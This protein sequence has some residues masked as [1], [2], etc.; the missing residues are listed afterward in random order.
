MDAG[1]RAEALALLARERLTVLAL[2]EDVNATASAGGS[3]KIVS[4]DERVLILS[5]LS[6]M[7]G[8]G[9]DLLE[10][11]ETVSSALSGRPAETALK[12]AAT[13]LRSGSSLGNSLRAAVQLPYPDYVYALIDAGEASG[14][15]PL[16]LDIAA[17]RLTE[18]RTFDR[19]LANAL[20]YPA[21]L[22]VSGVL[23]VAFLLYAVVP[24]FATMLAGSPTPPKGLAAIVIN[25]GVWFHAHALPVLIIT[26]VLG[27]FGAL[28][29]QTQEGAR[30]IAALTEAIP[31]VKSF[32]T[33][34]Q[35]A[36]WSRIM[37]LGLA[38]G[39][40]V[41]LAAGI[42]ARSLPEG[43]MKVAAL[44]AIPALRNGVPVDQAYLQAGVATALDASL[45]RAGQRSGAFGQMFGAVADRNERDMKDALKRIIMLAEPLAIA[46]VA[47]LIGSI[48]IG[49]V[50]ALVSIYDSV[51]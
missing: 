3:G 22:V 46:T 17:R 14:R 12:V 9:V 35:R 42:A 1:S 49:L 25:A 30:T 10:A 34:R 31:G 39:L 16:V 21:F 15:L 43:P 32:R 4:R 44:A 18:E 13:K 7:T 47:A 23:S 2:V 5:Q 40:D 37:A 27:A 26:A 20:V 24:R 8:A 29:G 11:L 36:S 28:M 19:D 38:S 6:V 48:V 41:L 50:S 33:L 51:G 45:I